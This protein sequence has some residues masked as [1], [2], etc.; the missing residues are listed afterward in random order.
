MI[1][2]PE[3]FP[4]VEAMPSMTRRARNR[5]AAGMIAL[6]ILAGTFLFCFFLWFA[7]DSLGSLVR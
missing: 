1:I 3:P 7:F 5:P 4:R 2:N 6:V